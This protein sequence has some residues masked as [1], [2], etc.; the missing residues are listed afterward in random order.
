M[1]ADQIRTLSTETHASSGQIREALSRLDA[2]S[3]KMTASIEETLKLIQITLEKV[4]HTGIRCDLI[5]H[6]SADIFR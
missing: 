3:A 2:T 1:V 6:S 4:T 5:P